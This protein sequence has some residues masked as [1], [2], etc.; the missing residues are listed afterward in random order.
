[1]NKKLVTAEFGDTLWKFFASVRLTVVLL[2]TLAIT[3]IIGTLIP[4]NADQASYIAK[5]GITMLR[6][7]MVLDLTDMYHSTWFRFFMGMLTVNILVCS[8]DRLSA[9]LKIVFVKNPIFSLSRFQALPGKEEFLSARSPVEL[10]EKYRPHIEKRFG[11][12]RVD[13]TDEGKCIFAEKGRWSRLSFYLVHLSIVFLLLGGLI[14]SIFGF[15]GFVNIPVGE[16]VA[17]V[18]LTNSPNRIPLGFSIRCDDFS[19]SF[20]ETGQPKEFRSRLSLIEDEKVILSQDIIVNSPLRFRGI[21]IFQSS[22]GPIAPKAVM[23]RFEDR[24][25]QNVFEVNAAIGQTID[26]P[27]NLG[28]FTL[29]TVTDAIQFKGMDIG[30]ALVGEL[31]LKDKDPEEILL[32]LRFPNFDRMRQ[33]HF[34]I[35]PGKVENRYYTGLQVTRDPGVWFVYTGFIMLI[36]GCFVTFFMAHQRLCI[37]MVSSGSKCRVIVTGTA[38]KNK[39]GMQLQV[40][41]IA[42]QLKSI[43]G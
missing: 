18:R 43:E 7:F 41:K 27:N 6:I 24:E 42:I 11:Y 35:T 26:L 31:R 16:S 38:N 32:P 12:V 10:I 8:F 9:T 39:L 33:G 17:E 25:T 34:I 20:Y 13:T 14:G 15:D 30:Q 29:K 22:Y 5:F 3:S 1:M 36:G 2:L 19:V 40:K 21:N 4:Q 37:Q 28:V 23:L